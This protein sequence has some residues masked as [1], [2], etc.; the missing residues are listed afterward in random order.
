MKKICPKCKIEK[1][2]ADYHKDSRKKIGIR[3]RC[4]ACCKVET[5]NWREKNK[6]HYNNYAAMWRSKNP[7]RQHATE[8]KRHYKLSIEKY[9]E[10][11]TKQKMKCVICDRQHDPSLKRGR[12]Y[13]DHNHETGAVRGLLCANCNKGLGC[14]NED[15][16]SLEQ[17]IAYLKFN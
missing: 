1:L 14:F 13:V 17:A 9:N 8:I 10:L 6:S 12:L 11:L 4:K 16:I 15:L 3:S 2:H 7:D 5:N